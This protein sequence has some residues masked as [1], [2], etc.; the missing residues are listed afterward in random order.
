MANAKKDK[1]KKEYSKEVSVYDLKQAPKVNNKWQESLATVEKSGMKISEEQAE[2]YN[3]NFKLSGSF[4][5]VNE[6]DTKK[7]LEMVAKKTGAVK[8][9]KDNKED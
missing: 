8:S 2:T 6:S 4:Y 7:Y 9:K 3:E 5:E 1:E